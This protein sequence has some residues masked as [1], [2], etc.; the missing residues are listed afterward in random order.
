MLTILIGRAGAGKS[1]RVLETMEKNRGE[2]PQ[3]LLVPEHVSHEAE[4]DLCRVMGPTASRDTEALSFRAFS[5]R[6]LQ[7]TGGTAEVTLDQG[8]KILTMRRCLQDLAP[9]LKVFGT[10]SRRS[11]FLQELVRLC[12]EFYAY[13]ILPE[14]L[15]Q[16][17]ENMPGASGDKLRDVALLFGSYDARLHST[18]MDVR[19]RMQKLRDRLGESSYLLGKDL[20]L[21]GFSFFNRLEESVIETAL[22]QCHDV[23]VTLLGD[24]KRNELFVN[25]S[26]QRDRLH[27]MAAQ[28]GVECRVFYLQAEGDSPICHL[29]KYFFGPDRVWEKPCANIA[30]YRAT[31]AFSEV[32]YVASRIR[33]LAAEGVRY[34]DIAVAARNMDVY[35]PLLEMVF[36]RDQI[37]AYISRRSDISEKP[38]LT[39]LLGALDAVTG[40]FEY[41]DMFRYLKTGLAGLQQADYDLLENYVITWQ[42]RGNMWLRETPWSANPD[43]Y[44][45]EMTPRRQEQ[46]DRIHA[47][48]MRVREPLLHLSE[49]LNSAPDART[50]A[51]VLFDFAVESGVPATLEERSRE[52]LQ[53]GR[54]QLAE[55]YSQLW[56]IFCDVLDQFVELLG[57]VQL[58]PEEFS[59]L[60]HLLLTQY[61]VGTIPATLD[62]VK[63]SEITRNDRHSVKYMFLLGAN[64]HILPQ[65]QKEAGILDDSDRQALQQ[66]NILLSDATFDALD[67]ELQNIY[68]C[69]AQ[70]TEYLHISWP[71]VDLSGS[72]LMP[73]FVVERVKRLFPAVELR[74]E[75]EDFR[76]TLPEEALTLAAQNPGGELWNYF[77]GNGAY[78]DILSA[79][80]RACAMQRGHLSPPAVEA[81]YG[82]SISLSASR[83]DKMR[84][85]HFGYFMEYGLRAKERKSAGFEAPE[86]GTFLHYL[87]ENVAREVK[88][89]GGFGAVERKKL[90]ELVRI[91]S[92]RYVEDHIP[93]YDAKSAR[94]KYLFSRLRVTAYAIV[95]AMAEELAQSDFEPL[96]F[97]L[98]F[99]GTDSGIPAITITQ[100]DT[101]LRVNGKVDRVDGWLH[102]GK[103]YL[104]VVDYKTGKK[105]FDLTDIRYGLGIQMLLYLFALEGV[106]EQYFGYPVVPAGVL[107]HSARNDMVKLS[108]GATQE[109]LDKELRKQLRRSGLVLESP[110]VLRAMEHDALEKPCY[111]P[112]HVKKDGT[113][114]EGIAT[115]QQLG[116]LSRY[117]DKLLHQMA[118]EIAAGNID[119]DPCSH[120]PRSSACDYCPFRSACYFEEGRDRRRYMQK[121]TAQDFWPFVEKEVGHA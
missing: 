22:T 110:E 41:E 5:G 45:A 66:Q 75:K 33:K 100:G 4:M 86:I 104:R 8:G 39:M 24:Q 48:R 62:Q 23:T 14:N 81:L 76:T 31:T 15:Y 74:C 20:Y 120:D 34:R 92:K 108:R 63:I 11:N 30:L 12:D 51:Q 94:F 93:G 21:D 61:S 101:S 84:S 119:A 103:L 49:G 37:P 2:R 117:V 85:C 109:D 87:L 69:L 95:D 38:V 121:T 116:H 40:G 32:E 78:A 53:T 115:A 36:R 6:V 52:L 57:A 71:T 54:V 7:E 59:R 35:G 99:G 111:L 47:A 118:G 67:N 58:R 28:K 102:D 107:Y 1:R 106:G 56:R 73:S 77:A 26:V 98:A 43:G 88:G 60:F 18:D 27:R 68:A 96:A 50:M 17:V 105:A 82:K 16:T 79:M 42:I 29:E 97:E 80:E 44:G 3:L 13:E 19:S 9:K 83:M 70:P 10:P 55:E 46:L 112:I 114:T 89:R 90:H 72:Q 65:V 91:Y 25:A 113:I 64:D